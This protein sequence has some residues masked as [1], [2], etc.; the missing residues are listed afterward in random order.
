MTIGS[1]FQKIRKLAYSLSTSEVNLRCFFGY[2]LPHLI[3]QKKKKKSGSFFKKLF[4]ASSYW[5]DNMNKSKSYQNK[6]ISD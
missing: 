1:A 3:K 6:K 4:F 2:P 5:Q